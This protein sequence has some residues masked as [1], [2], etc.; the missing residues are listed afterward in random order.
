MTF[1]NIRRP[2]DVVLHAEGLSVHGLFQDLTFHLRGG[3]RLAITGPNGSGKTTLLR[4]L[5]GQQHL[6]AGAVRLGT[7]VETASIEQVLEQQLDFSR[8]PLEICGTTAAA[9]TLLA[10]LKVP[11]AC[12]NRPLRTLSGG[13]R[14]KVAMASILNSTANLLLLD[15]PT[16][17]LEIEAQEALEEALRSYPGTVIAVSHDRSFLQGLG[18]NA[19]VID[20]RTEPSL[21]RQPTPRQRRRI[22]HLR[23]H[24]HPRRL[25][26]IHRQH[27]HD[28]FRRRHQFHPLR[29]RVQPQV[30]PDPSKSHQ[31][32]LS[33]PDRPALCQQLA[34]KCRFLQRVRMRSP[35][36][37]RDPFRLPLL[38]ISLYLL[39]IF[40][41]LPLQRI[42][43]I[44]QI[45]Q[46][47]HY[48]V[49]QSVGR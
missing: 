46:E 42:Q 14:T 12:L 30:L 26:P 35:R 49:Y 9:R 10:C 34:R 20:L 18:E 31:D 27:R 8:S 40:F 17:H 28:P 33:V 38:A 45:I 11:V 7:N 37:R 5:T 23:I 6:D 15:E 29:L 47:T 22:V 1:D 2:S 25:R 43:I 41:L 32:A 3:G 39:G 19:N 4:V 21:P 24:R 13:E 16:N 36:Q 44:F 48:Y